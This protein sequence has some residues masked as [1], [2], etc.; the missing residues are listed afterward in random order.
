MITHYIVKIF[1][2][3]NLYIFPAIRGHSYAKLEHFYTLFCISKGEIYAR[4]PLSY[5]NIKLLG[6]TVLWIFVTAVYLLKV[7]EL[8]LEGTSKL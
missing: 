3:F 4:A 8:R 6:R 5:W 2:S 1:F 7:S